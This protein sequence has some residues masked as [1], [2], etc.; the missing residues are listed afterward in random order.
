MKL[1]EPLF[2][3]P[4]LPAYDLPSDLGERYG[5]RLGFATPRLY[6]NFVSSIDGVV[7]LGAMPASPSVISGRSE[8]DR[9]VMG[10]LRACA[11]AVLIGAGT[12]RAEPEHLWTP[13]HVYPEA[14]DAYALLRR[15][16]GLPGRPLLVVITAS[17]E[18][19]THVPALALGALIVTTDR[20]AKV[21]GRSSPASDAAI[22]RVGS[23]GAIELG[24]VVEELRM[25]GYG[26]ILTEGGPKVVGQL[27]RERLLDELFL[28][29][30]P[31]L[32]GRISSEDRPGVVDGVDLVS[33][34]HWG[35]LVSLRRHRSHLFA[36][37]RLESSR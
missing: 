19:D 22:V 33:P 17:G 29:I 25:Q 27:A 8:A 6:A 7:A 32:A 1:L 26:V 24:G 30:S 15:R 4:G 34:P 37:Y 35:E 14:G 36:R 5:G 11:Q 20:G 28:T 13:E 3:A 2:E 12:L 23:G 9:F 10:L 31:M 21:L 18:V 16:L